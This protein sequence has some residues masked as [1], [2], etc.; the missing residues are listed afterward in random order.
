[1]KCTNCNAEID[2]NAKFCT[3]CGTKTE[4]HIFCANCGTKL[5][6]GAM[7]C[8]NCGEKVG[9]ATIDIQEEKKCHIHNYETSVTDRTII[10]PNKTCGKEVSA[11][12]TECPFC[13]TSL[14]SGVSSVENGSD[15]TVNG[16]DVTD[17]NLHFVTHEP[18]IFQK[19]LQVYWLQ[20]KAWRLKEFIVNNGNICVSVMNGKELKAPIKDCC[21]YYD[22]ADKYNRMVITIKCGDKKIKF[23]EIPFMLEDEEWAQFIKEHQEKS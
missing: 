13:G 14:H 20:P 2:D 18:T 23:V 21:F 8:S 6:E 11:K 1:M 7:F 19:I 3:E 5:E 15:K 10:C 12:F 9:N 4:M 17:I 16:K 22:D